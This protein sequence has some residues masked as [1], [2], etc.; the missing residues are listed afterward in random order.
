MPGT[1]VVQLTTTDLDSP[2]LLTPLVYHVTGGDTRSQFQIRG[3]GE[4]YVAKALDRES[5]PRYDLAITATDGK[6]VAVTRV[7]IDILDANGN[8]YLTIYFYITLFFLFHN[9]YRY[10]NLK[11][12]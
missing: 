5:I 12:K 1:V 10:F 2:E 4:L 8:I 11:I 9:M 6:F 3:T 7:S